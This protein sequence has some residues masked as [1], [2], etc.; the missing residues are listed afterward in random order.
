MRVFEKRALEKIFGY[1]E[2]ELTGEWRIQQTILLFTPL[3][4]LE[5]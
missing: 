3:L 5:L 1:K 4:V 2:E